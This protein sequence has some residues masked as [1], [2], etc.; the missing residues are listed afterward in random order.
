MQENRIVAIKIYGHNFAANVTDRL[1]S[2][3][4]ALSEI[5]ALM[6]RKTLVN[7]Y[8]QHIGV[9]GFIYCYISLF[10]KWVT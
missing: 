3:L 8:V 7:I 5:S 6:V 10:R 4:C 1:Q 9:N 2:N